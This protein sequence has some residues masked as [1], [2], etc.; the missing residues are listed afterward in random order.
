M[1]AEPL[2]VHQHALA[3]RTTSPTAVCFAGESRT[4]AS[5][6]V[7]EIQKRH[8]VTP[9]RADVFLVLSPPSEDDQTTALS[10]S[11]L[12]LVEQDLEPIGTVVAND[13]QMP[14]VLRRLPLPAAET[15]E[16]LD[17]MSAQPLPHKR[18]RRT[19]ADFR[20]W[21]QI[22]SCNPQLSLALRH[23]VCLSLIEQAEAA[24]RD[25]R[26][27]DWVVRTRP[28]IALPCALPPAA[29]RP[30]Q[31]RYYID[32]IALM[33]RAAAGT[34][35]REVP[36]AR[37]WNVSRCY[38]YRDE[39]AMGTCN[40]ALAHAAGWST[41][42]LRARVWLPA[43][44][45]GGGVGGDDGGGGGFHDVDVA[46]PARPYERGDGG[47]GG[48]EGGGGGGHEHHSREVGL[49]PYPPFGSTASMDNPAVPSGTLYPHCALADNATAAQEAEK[50]QRRARGTRGGAGGANGAAAVVIPFLV[51]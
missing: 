6:R 42:T 4:F 20:G 11:R 41:G 29:L 22:G 39:N 14:S 48:G 32:F 10:A 12:Q 50:Q 37:R 49:F 28:D 16:I 1:T 17:C 15:R 27:Y 38:S 31:V 24:R 47:G 23:R 33:P 30:A 35:L 26:R 51:D 21:F 40:V 3:R 9:L 18:V 34:L 7:R 25:A 43:E 45:S 5:H 13:A 19:D 8:L 36:L 46:F 2:I 44:K